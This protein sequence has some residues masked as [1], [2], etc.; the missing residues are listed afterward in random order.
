MAAR[1]GLNGISLTMFADK[2]FN[3]IDSICN[4]YKIPLK[5][6]EYNPDYIIDPRDRNLN[7]M[8]DWVGLSATSAF[9]EVSTMP[10]PSLDVNK[11]QGKSHIQDSSVEDHP[12]KE[13][14]SLQEISKLPANK[15]QTP[16]LAWANVVKPNA[17]KADV[18][19]SKV[20]DNSTTLETQAKQIELLMKQVQSLQAALQSQH[21]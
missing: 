8:C 17:A 4:D 5:D 3:K 6:M 21:D 2:E 15:H 16:R 13:E 14:P 18:A 1:R 7:D 20:V 11:I 12:M 19:K 10:E 9:Q